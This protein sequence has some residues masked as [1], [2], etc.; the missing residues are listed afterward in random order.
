MNTT[1]MGH[2]K[3]SERRTKGKTGGSNALPKGEIY[4]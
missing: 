4:I 2:R 1:F 3:T